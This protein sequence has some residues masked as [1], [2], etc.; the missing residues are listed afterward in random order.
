[1]K[2]RPSAVDTKGLKPTPARVIGPRSRAH[3]CDSLHPERPEYHEWQH[4]D[5]GRRKCPQD[6]LT[7]LPPSPRPPLRPKR[8]SL[9]SHPPLPPPKSGAPSYSHLKRSATLAPLGPLPPSTDA[10]TEPFRSKVGFESV[11]HS[12]GEIKPTGLSPASGC[13]SHCWPIVGSLS[14]CDVPGVT[15]SSAQRKHERSLRGAHQGASS[16]SSDP[17]LL[18]FITQC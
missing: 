11:S 7:N 15:P 17:C 5:L 1:M 16:T 2:V 6:V 3:L 18:W 10:T 12:Q 9:A 4:L 14:S 13:Q 8:L